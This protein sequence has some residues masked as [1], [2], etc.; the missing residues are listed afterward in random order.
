M[1][2]TERYVNFYDLVVKVRANHAPVPP[3]MPLIELWQKHGKD[4]GL[5]HERDKGSLRYRVGDIQV[6]EATV[7]AVMLIRRADQNAPNA[8]F[9][10]LETGQ[11]R[12]AKKEANEGGDTA[13]HIVLSLN[14]L[15]P[16]TYLC[17]VE[18][19]PGLSHRVAQ[20]LLN[21][22]I[23]QACKGQGAG[24]GNDK[25]PILFAYKD[26]AG[27]KKVTPCQPHVELQS[28]LSE[29][30]ARDLDEGTLQQVELIKSA[31]HKPLGGDQ[32]LVEEEHRLL[33][34][35]DKKIPPNNRLARLT[36]A[37]R[38]KVTEFDKA[39]IQFKDRNDRS[40]RVDVSL[41]QGTPEQKLYVSAQFDAI[42][43]PLD[44]SS[45]TIQPQLSAR[46][47]QLLLQERDGG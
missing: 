1:R 39:R 9:S 6:D 29:D 31:A 30:L 17:L 22:L 23:R 27:G 33:I 36:K 13:A 38:G 15:E 3:I 10:N 7:L 8:T 21:D 14:P 43:P 2:A 41:D 47:V 28:Y 46:M 20:G 11:L 44:Q 42:N 32:Y 19:V 45:E 18:S 26:A 24:R 34:K 35:P 25:K 4:G 37:W 12:V 16:N 5:V 40:H